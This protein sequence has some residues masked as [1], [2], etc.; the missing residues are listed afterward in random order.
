MFHQFSSSV[1]KKRFSKTDAG[2]D[3]ETKCNVYYI[4]VYYQKY[5][6]RDA[7][8]K[9]S[10][11]RTLNTKLLPVV[12]A[13]T[14]TVAPAAIGVCVQMGEWKETNWIEAL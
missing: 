7:S 4:E 1:K 2:S 3:E 13:S 12:P 9:V 10:L 8:F 6:N 5:T 14:F 11:G